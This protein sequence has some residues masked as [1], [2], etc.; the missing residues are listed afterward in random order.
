M[1]MGRQPQAHLDQLIPNPHA[2]VQQK[3]QMQKDSHDQTSRLRTFEIDDPVFI[4][5][6]TSSPTW[7][8]GTVLQT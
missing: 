8:P 7:L 1:L 2:Q 6:F 4:C 5:N 3:Q